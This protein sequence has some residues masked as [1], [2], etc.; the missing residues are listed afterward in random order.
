MLHVATPLRV[1]TH[2][3]LVHI[4][5]IEL[6]TIFLYHVPCASAM[7]QLQTKVLLPPPLVVVVLQKFLQVG[8]ASVGKHQRYYEHLRIFHLVLV[9]RQLG[10]LSEGP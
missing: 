9:G 1:S 10:Q 2:H 7:L 8:E 5:A 3:E 4:L 6:N